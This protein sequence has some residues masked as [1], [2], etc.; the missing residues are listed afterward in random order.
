M[1]R[2][3]YIDESFSNYIS[4]FHEGDL[5]AAENNFILELKNN[6]SLGYEYKLEN[7]KLLLSKL[8]KRDF[9]NANFYNIYLL[10][11]LLDNSGSTDKHF[12]ECFKVAIN[13]I[14]NQTEENKVYP[15]SRTIKLKGIFL[16]LKI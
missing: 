7:L 15:M 6:R 1:L 12:Q 13:T 9:K 8:D 2:R 14:C 4:Y 5:S 16:M 11:Y 3:G 10:D